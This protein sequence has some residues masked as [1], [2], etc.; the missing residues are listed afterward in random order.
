MWII[1]SKINFSRYKLWNRLFLSFY[2]CHFWLKLHVILSFTVQDDWYINNLVLKFCGDN[3]EDGLRMLGRHPLEV[4]RTS[5]IQSRGCFTRSNSRMRKIIN[6]MSSIPNCVLPVKGNPRTYP[7]DDLRPA[8]ALHECGIHFVRSNEKS[9][10]GIDFD[11]KS[12][13]LSLP[14]LPIHD[15]TKHLLLNMVV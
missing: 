10:M 9:L 7:R 5:L 1:I 14:V 4:Y 6:K 11:C 15:A 3:L 8:T 12:G 2:I 13:K